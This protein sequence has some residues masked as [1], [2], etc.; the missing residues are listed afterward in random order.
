MQTLIIAA[1]DESGSALL[2]NTIA[3]DVAKMT[4][5]E[6]WKNC[7]AY[8]ARRPDEHPIAFYFRQMTELQPE[9][10]AHIGAERWGR[11]M[12]EVKRVRRREMPKYSEKH[13]RY[14]LAVFNVDMLPPEEKSL[15]LWAIFAD[16]YANTTAAAS[17]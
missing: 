17:Q 14:V 10:L 11:F 4:P 7:R 2:P 12:A 5:R 13:E 16:V 1:I 15:P 3:R 6:E 8:G 9:I